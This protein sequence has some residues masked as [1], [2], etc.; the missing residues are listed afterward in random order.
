MRFRNRKSL[1]EREGE[2]RVVRKFLWWPRSLGTGETRWLEFARIT[3][4]VFGIRAP[5]GFGQAA[6][7][8]LHGE[9]PGSFIGWEWREVGFAPDEQSLEGKVMKGGTNPDLPRKPPP[10]ELPKAQGIRSFNRYY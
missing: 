9:A 6:Y 1:R 8:Y 3:E 5:F 10:V 7:V 4:K 2:T